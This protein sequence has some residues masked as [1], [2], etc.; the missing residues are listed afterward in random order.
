MALIP[1]AEAQARM[2]ALKAPL[3]VETVP[4]LDA[5][6]RF[7]AGDIRARRTQPAADLS[8]MDGYAIRFAERP[9]PWTVA[10]ESAAGG[11]FG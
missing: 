1:V 3:A 7:A 6:G 8:A 10:G 2:L 11:G 4:L 5:A 9:G